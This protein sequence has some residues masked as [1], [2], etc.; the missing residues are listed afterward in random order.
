MYPGP[1]WAP[2]PHLP[3]PGGPGGGSRFPPC[4]SPKPL[5]GG[6]RGGGGELAFVLPPPR[7]PPRCGKGCGGG[8]RC[9]PWAPLPAEAGRG[10]ARDGGW[11]GGRV[12]PGAEPPPPATWQRE[13][14]PRLTLP[15]SEVPRGRGE[16]AARRAGGGGV[17]LWGVLE[18]GWW[19]GSPL[20]KAV[21]CINAAC[22]EYVSTRPSLTRISPV[23]K[24]AAVRWLSSSGVLCFCALLLL[25][26]FVAS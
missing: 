20:H 18:R 23:S 8:A 9:R 24:A 16:G 10:R 11:D 19:Q 6:G 1:R 12:P 21:S 25:S 2:G 3:G 13:G 15:L 4:G 5:K 26:L 14:L 17:G 7:F 22:T